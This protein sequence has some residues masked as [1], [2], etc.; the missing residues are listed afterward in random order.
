MTAIDFINLIITALRDD[1]VL[2]SWCQSEFGKALTVFSGIDDRNPPR[3]ED[4]PLVALVGVESKRGLFRAKGEWVASLSV[5]VVNEAV[6]RV[7]NLVTYPG[8]AQV[9]VLREMAE[10]A[11]FRLRPGDGESESAGV[12]FYPIFVSYTD[13][14]IPYKRSNRGKTIN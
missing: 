6:S 12:S 13:I 11:I 1:E 8:Q 10:E 3:E 9:E 5:G 4:Y 2:Q 7:D 14:I